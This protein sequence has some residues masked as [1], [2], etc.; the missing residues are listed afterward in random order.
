VADSR[1]SKQRYYR[2]PDCGGWHR[3]HEV[4][5]CIA[6]TKQRA[7]DQIERL[8]AQAFGHGARHA[9]LKRAAERLNTW[10]ESSTWGAAVREPYARDD[11][12]LSGYIK[13]DLE[14]WKRLRADLEVWKR[15]HNGEVPGHGH[16]SQLTADEAALVVAHWRLVESEAQKIA[17]KD[18]ELYYRLTAVGRAELEKAVRRWDITREI[19]FGAFVRKRIR[20]SM[21]NY[22]DREWNPEQEPQDFADDN[23]KR[24]FKGMTRAPRLAAELDAMFRPSPPAETRR[25]PGKRSQCMIEAA[26]AK[27]NTRQQAV[28]RGMVLTKPPLS[29]AAMAR[30]LGI[31]DVTQISRILKQARRKMLGPD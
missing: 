8:L 20:G 23:G 2:C 12:I 17:P 27:L 10:A 9:I 16:N 28:Y 7:I 22:L 13:A 19:T 15:L 29:R 11:H 3:H 24:W 1:K 18:P 14:E 5:P 30:Q 31:A 25:I 6:V 21:L 4:A 26:L